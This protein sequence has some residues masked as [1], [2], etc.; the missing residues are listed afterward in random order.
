MG[1]LL[2]LR[3][4]ITLRLPNGSV[5]VLPMIAITNAVMECKEIDHNFSLGEKGVP[6]KA[7]RSYKLQYNFLNLNNSLTFKSNQKFAPHTIS[8]FLFLSV[9]LRYQTRLD[10]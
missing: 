5:S 6:F 10:I 1:Y 4:K 8:R 3:K 9:A 7:M 2:I